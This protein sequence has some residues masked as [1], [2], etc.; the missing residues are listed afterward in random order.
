MFGVL[1]LFKVA[2]VFSSG[3]EWN[4]KELLPI[5]RIVEAKWWILSDYEMRYCCDEVKW[6]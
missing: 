4:E 3:Q 2:L 6:N 5:S 1:L